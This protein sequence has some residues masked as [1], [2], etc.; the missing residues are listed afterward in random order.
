MAF[1]VSFAIEAGD[2]LVSIKLPCL[3]TGKG[4]P[5]CCQEI[6]CQRYDFLGC[7]YVSRRINSIVNAGRFA[8]VIDYVHHSDMHAFS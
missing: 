6:S 7:T 2:L 4:L 3:N 8:D 5:V 1:H